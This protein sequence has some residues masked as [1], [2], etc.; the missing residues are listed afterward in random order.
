MNER[1]KRI[2][3]KKLDQDLGQAEIIVDDNKSIWF[4][5]RAKK[6]WYLE[7]RSSG[8]LW[9]R[10][11]FFRDFFPLFDLE[12]IE[13]EPVIAEWVEQVLK[14]GVSSTIS[15]QIIHRKA[16]EEVLKHEVSSTLQSKI[17]YQ[18]QVEEVLKREVS[19][20]QRNHMN[21]C[22]EME[23]A[24]KRGVY[25]TQCNVGLQGSRPVEEVLK[26]KASPTTVDNLSAV[27]AMEDA[28][29]LG[30]SSFLNFDTPRN[31]EV[32]RALN[33]KVSSTFESKTSAI[34]LVEKILN[35]ERVSTNSKELLPVEI[36]KV[37]S[38]KAGVRECKMKIKKILKKIIS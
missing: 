35:H 2:I 28:L 14:R 7:L 5:D 25:S 18:N 12:R 4:I 30:V 24:L 6:Y 37:L 19:S 32:G 20:I 23:E 13:Y 10:Y 34:S 17:D 31:R 16:V 27:V 36:K 15:D 9:W 22:D 29:K 8:T 33:N 21:D 11:S 3:F 38:L 1:L 26:P